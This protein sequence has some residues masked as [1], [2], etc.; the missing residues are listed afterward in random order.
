MSSKAPPR[1]APRLYLETPDANDVES[2]KSM[3][4]EALAAADVAAVL[5]RLS[6]SDERGHINLV[7]ALA[8]TIQ[9][10]GAAL[11]LDGYAHLAVR[12]GA[13]GAHVDGIAL[14]EDAADTLKP[15]HLLGIGGLYS[16]HDSMVA[17]EKGADYLLFGRPGAD[18]HRPLP[19]DVTEQIGW[20]AELFEPP[21]VGY[22][23]TLDEVE[24]FADAGADFVM[25]GDAVWNDPR[26]A[27]AALG[28]AMKALEQGYQ[29]SLARMAHK[30]G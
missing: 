24:T 6:G 14:L 4:S 29:S 26:G 15:N 10:A 28:N 21:C 23:M 20:W 18:G 2:I 16:R 9:S 19:E 12:A 3:L 17:G 1:P 11:L 5:V 8:S 27:K 30:L 13:D 22:A 25:L 7:K